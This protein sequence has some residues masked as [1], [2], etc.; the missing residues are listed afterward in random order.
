MGSIDHTLFNQQVI[1]RV[2]QCGGSR[3]FLQSLYAANNSECSSNKI[4]DG[5]HDGQQIALY[6]H[7]IATRHILRKLKG[8]PLKKDA[9]SVNRVC[10]VHKCL[11]VDIFENPD[12]G[13]DHH[14]RI[15]SSFES[16]DSSALAVVF[17]STKYLLCQGW[18]SKDQEAT[19]PKEQICFVRTWHRLAYLRQLRKGSVK[20]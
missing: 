6:V 4:I 19:T 14:Y 12:H 3:H 10:R 1:N 18:E 2:L 8:L 9:S 5:N 16:S 7:V 11:T 13:L 20:L 17:E 15:G